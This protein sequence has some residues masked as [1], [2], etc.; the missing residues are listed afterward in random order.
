VLFRRPTVVAA[1]EAEEASRAEIAAI[2]SR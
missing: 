1:F 2:S